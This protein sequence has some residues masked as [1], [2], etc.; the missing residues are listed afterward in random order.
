MD[1]EIWERAGVKGTPTPLQGTEIAEGD[2]GSMGGGVCINEVGEEGVAS[3]IPKLAGTGRNK[4]KV[5]TLHCL[6]RVGIRKKSYGR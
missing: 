5:G 4:K 3:R 1:V 6:V 2:R